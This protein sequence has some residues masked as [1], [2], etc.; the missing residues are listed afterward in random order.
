[1]QLNLW[2]VTVTPRDLNVQQIAERAQHEAFATIASE[3]AEAGYPVTGD[4]APDEVLQLDNAFVSF[5]LAM[6]RNN[7]TIARLQELD[8]RS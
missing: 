7:D 2:E 3:M 1:M 6:A 5:V 8:E 4:F